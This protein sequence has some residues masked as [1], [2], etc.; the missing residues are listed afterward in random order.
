MKHLSVRRRGLARAAIA[1]MAAAALF[2][3]AGC[4]SG[5]GGTAPT[6]GGG[7][8]I[9]PMKLRVATYT[10]ESVG[11]AQ[12]SKKW[13]DLV[14]EKTDGAITFEWFY[15]GQLFDAVALREAVG[16]G[17]VD[18]GLFSHGYF[19]AEMPLSQSMNLGFLSSNVQA[20]G[21]THQWMWENNEA[22]RAEWDRNKVRPV[23]W[24]LEPATT[25]GCGFEIDDLGILKGK[26]VRAASLITEDFT[27]VGSNVVALQATEIL[28]AMERGVVDCYGAFG[29]S[30][31][32]DTGVAL[33]SKRIYDYG[34]GGNGAQELVIGTD[35]WASLPEA[36]QTAMNEAT[37]EVT[38]EW[39]QPDG[40]QASSVMAACEKVKAAGGIVEV[41]AEDLRKEWAAVG[42]PANEKK[43]LEI[44][45]AEGP[46]FLKEYKAKVKE[47][48]KEF[49][50]YVD[51]TAA[52][53]ATF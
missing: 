17:A 5:G 47:F 25:V 44:A 3:L 18:M 43:F 30:L 7:G 51:P 8:D 40:L 31:A 10:G 11:S 27:S 12:A 38:E 34:R 29:L 50:D 46:D 16:N 6:E 9:K 49:P 19:N 37:A 1:S 2:A 39:Y 15:Q 13:T 42:G 4:T 48:E 45:G 35:L 14:T 33:I 21:A 26:N 52:C 20:V 28:D 32:T 36:V 23:F 24:G 22:Y 41:L 53:A